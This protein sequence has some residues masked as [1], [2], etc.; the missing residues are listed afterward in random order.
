ML[1]YT[2]PGFHTGFQDVVAS[3]MKV[4]NRISDT[5]SPQTYIRLQDLDWLTFEVLRTCEDF[6]SPDMSANLFRMWKG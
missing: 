2:W 1:W 3:C 6:S 4:E 5:I